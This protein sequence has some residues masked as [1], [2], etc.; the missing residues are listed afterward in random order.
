MKENPKPRCQARVSG[1]GSTGVEVN[2][3]MSVI[4]GIKKRRV[5]RDFEEKKEERRDRSLGEM[6]VTGIYVT[7]FAES[8]RRSVNPQG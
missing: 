1:V 5:G 4:S 8:T 3:Q 6:I 7:Q 2:P